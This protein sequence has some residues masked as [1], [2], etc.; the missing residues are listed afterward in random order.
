MFDILKRT[1]L[2][3]SDN[4][5]DWQITIDAPPYTNTDLV[6]YKTSHTFKEE[7][8]HVF[9]E[10]MQTSTSENT[11]F[12]KTV[13]Y[14][15]T[16][17]DDDN[18]TPKEKATL[19][20]QVMSNITSSITN[21]AMSISPNIANK[22]FRLDDEIIMLKNQRDI[23]NQTKQYKINQTKEQ[24]EAAKQNALYAKERIAQLV[25]AAKDNNRIQASKI[26]E[27]LYGQHKIGGGVITSDMW[28]LIF[29]MAKNTYNNVD[30]SIA[31]NTDTISTT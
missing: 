6:E 5:S 27:E 25:K 26:I 20:A 23:S 17:L 16:E 15:Q 31:T 14:L 21:N 12:D 28:K 30:A 29:E 18:L 22:N 13:K 10:L 3:L 8:L 2:S 24:A 11:P 1:R 9:K 4:W 19:K 7:T